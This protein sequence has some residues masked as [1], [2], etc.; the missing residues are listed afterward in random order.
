[1]SKTLASYV[2]NPVQSVCVVCTATLTSV[3]WRPSA[4]L[5]ATGQM[6]APGPSY[7]SCPPSS[8]E[9]TA[10]PHTSA[11]QPTRYVSPQP[12]C[13]SHGKQSHK[14]RNLGFK[15]VLMFL[16]FG[17]VRILSSLLTVTMPHMCIE[18]YHAPSVH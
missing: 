13:V 6:A 14:S 10:S 3:Q 18:S 9:R 7:S 12:S 8:S 1:M 5:T 2:Q 16:Q 15:Y 4:A 11:V 17:V